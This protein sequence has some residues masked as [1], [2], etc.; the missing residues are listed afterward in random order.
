MKTSTI[1]LYDAATIDT[2]PWPNHPDALN[3]KK[4]LIPL[5]KNGVKPY[6][7]NVD[8]TMMALVLDDIVM[9]LTVNEG[10]YE[11]SYVCSPYG[12]YF[13]YGLDTVDKLQRAYV[14]TPLKFLLKRMQKTFERGKLNKVV[15]V[16]NWLV[17]TN[18][19][20]ELNVEQI[21]QM[22]A[23]LSRQFPEHAIVFRSINLYQNPVKCA[24]LKK[25]A[26]DLIAS[27]KIYLFKTDNP[28]AYKQRMFQS[29]MKLYRS[30]P[31]QIIDSQELTNQEIPRLADLYNALYIDKHSKQNPQLSAK[32]IELAVRENILTLKVLKKDDRIDAVV[33]FFDRNGVMTSPLFGYDTSL[34]KEFGLYRL[35]STILTLE[36]KKKGVLLNQSSGA[37]SFKKLR[38]GEPH[39]EYMAV[40]T[41][42][43]PL[44]R[45]IPWKVLQKM[46]NSV[47]LLFMKHY[48]I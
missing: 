44:K 32:F 14:K 38:K 4:F 47:G 11:N 18:L 39:I 42:H 19:H 30:T 8:T 20:P 17:S 35:I 22:I 1:A 45:R 2:L 37:G 48:E 31:Y 33:G 25:C 24:S 3:A 36:A 10:E 28:A 13:N 7:H 21:N 29:D 12:Q 26:F 15:I 46:V 43:L 23:F 5:I 6:I 16:N 27:R 34:P 9:P 41:K 40:Y